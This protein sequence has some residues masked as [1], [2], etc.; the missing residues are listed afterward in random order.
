MALEQRFHGFPSA[1]ITLTYDDDH[2]ESPSLCRNDLKVF[3]DGVRREFGSCRYFAVGEYGSKTLRPHYH[4]VVFDTPGG[5]SYAKVFE[6]LWTKGFIQVGPAE[7]A[8]FN[9]VSGYVT[10]K[11]DSAHHLA[12]EERGLVPEFFSAS[13]RPPLGT[14][15]LVAI[16]RMMNTH[17]GAVAI[18]KHGFP[19]GFNLEGRYYP[20]FRRD[21]LKVIQMAG[22]AD[23]QNMEDEHWQ[24]HDERSWFDVEQ[25]EVYRRAELFEWP[26]ARLRAELS[27]LEE[28]QANEATENEVKRARARA[29]KFRRRE[30]AK[31]RQLDS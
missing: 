6:K 19:R 3:I 2:L 5:P 27:A 1:F 14:T 18:A 15:G 8:V 4:V 9:Y 17:H 29:T 24:R 21:R 26:P 7:G 12:I 11:L 31:R 28:K 22:Y 25:M 13:L 23:R 20:F 16:S 30:A 10:K